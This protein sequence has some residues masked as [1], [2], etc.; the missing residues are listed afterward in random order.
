[1][2]KEERESIVQEAFE[3][4][5]LHIPEV[6]GNLITNHTVMM[7]INKK[8]YKKYPEFQNH[9][10]AVMSVVEMMEAK[11]PNAGHEKL[12]TKSVPEI[13]KRIEQTKDMDVITVTDKP[14]RRFEPIP[15]ASIP[16][17]KTHGDL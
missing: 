12:L 11:N 4:I 2:E 13:R 6:I 5:M 10:D 1:M 16:E 14:N 7:E 8:F 17:I 15:S 3:R 9:K